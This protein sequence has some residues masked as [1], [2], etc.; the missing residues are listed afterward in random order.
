MSNECTKFKPFSELNYFTEPDGNY[1]SADKF[2]NDLVRARQ[3]QTMAAVN[4]LVIFDVEKI[5]KYH[6][7]TFLQDMEDET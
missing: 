2:K 7:R 6:M 3:I 5:F 4:P 1:I